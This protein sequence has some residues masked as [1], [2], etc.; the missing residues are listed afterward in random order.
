MVTDTARCIVHCCPLLATQQFDFQHS[1][2]HGYHITAHG[3]LNYD[4][5]H[6]DVHHNGVTRTTS[7]S[8]DQPTHPVSST[9]VGS[10]P[11][12]RSGH[13]RSSFGSNMS[14]GAGAAGHMLPQPRR[15]SFGSPALYSAGGDIGGLRR[16]LLTRLSSQ[17]VDDEG[18]EERLLSS[19]ESSMGGADTNACAAGSDA[20]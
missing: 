17:R 2:G 9:V 13:R 8:H 14:D 16:A 15:N 10:S 12:H 20:T 6:I 5:T 1:M 19:N 18:V 7:S 11:T 3:H 4:D